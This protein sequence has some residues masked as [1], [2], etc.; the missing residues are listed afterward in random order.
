MGTA[1]RIL[2]L[3]SAF[4]LLGARPAAAFPDLVP[5]VLTATSELVA[6]RNGNV[7]WTIANQGDQTAV[8]STDRLFFSSDG[9]LDGGDTFL[10]QFFPIP[11]PPAT[12]TPSIVVFPS[13]T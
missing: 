12:A 8:S 4:W 3:A 5:T 13:P 10:D 2:L 7:S 1:K 9:V 6:G 11:S